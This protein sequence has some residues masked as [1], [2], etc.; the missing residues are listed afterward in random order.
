MCTV[1]GIVWMKITIPVRMV[2]DQR[3]RYIRNFQP[4]QPYAQYLAYMEQGYVMKELRRAQREGRLPQAA[5]LY[6][7]ETKPVEELYDVDGDPH[8]LK[9][10]AN[11]P[12][13]K[14]VLEKLRAVQ[15]KWAGDPREAGLIPE[16]IL[17]DRGKKAGARYHV[18]RQPDSEKYIRA[19]RTL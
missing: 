7:G 10:L 3:Y 5:R 1:R 15:E 8:E 13:H 19:L 16:P 14:T 2:R 9:N 12:K 4:H 11:S 17:E 6:M 18:L